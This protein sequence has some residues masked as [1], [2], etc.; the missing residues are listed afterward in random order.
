V[1]DSDQ[2]ARQAVEAL[3]AGDTMSKALGIEVLM[4]RAGQVRISMQVRADM[5][6]G[7]GICHGGM[8]F[9]LADSA[10]AFACNSH[11][12][13]MVAAGAQ[14][15]YLAPARLGD[16]LIASA[17]EQFKTERLGI[18]DVTVESSSGT[19]I[20]EFRGRCARLRAAPGQA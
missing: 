9:S 3:L 1:E 17:R 2:R 20:A 15:E 14:I 8:I 7:H 4:L 5:A 11:G 13:K 10:F 12:I 19:R 6:N 16:T 18:Y